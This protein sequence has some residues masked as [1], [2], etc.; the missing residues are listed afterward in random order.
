M[1]EVAHVEIEGFAAA[2]LVAKMEASQMDAAPVFT[3]LKEFP[4]RKFRGRVD[5][6]TG[7]FPCQPFS[8]AGSRKAT[9]D[10]RHLFPF[11]LEGIR[12]CKPAVVF[13]ENVE[14]IISWKKW[15]T[16]QRQKYSQRVK[17][18]RPINESEYSSWGTPT[19]MS[20]PR[21]E[22]TLQKC[23]AFRQ[24]H[25]KTSV[26]LYLEEQVRKQWVSPTASQAEKPQ[27]PNSQ[28]KGLQSQVRKETWPTPT[29]AEAGKIGGNPNYGQLGLS[30]HPEVHGYEVQREPLHKDRKGLAKAGPPDQ[31]QTNTSGKPP[32]PSQGKLNPN[33]VE[34]LMGVEP[35]WTQLPTE[36][37]D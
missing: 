24:K 11:I 13:L 27:G 6:L 32:A 36:W 1:R 23:L 18:V 21:S 12:E 19:A 15:V 7:G 20:R 31:G 25:G 8:N 4:F 28:Q 14:G 33:W 22:A 9:E 3:N 26:P 16:E 10:P 5:I 29:V 35:Q 37:I 34:S 30:N 17:S 2:N